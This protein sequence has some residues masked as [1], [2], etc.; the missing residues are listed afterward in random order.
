MGLG[1][2]LSIVSL[3][4]STLP[5]ARKFAHAS[6][7]SGDSDDSSSGSDDDDLDA[8]HFSS[9][10]YGMAAT[11]DLS[12]GK[13]RK[14]AEGYKVGPNKI[15]K[16]ERKYRQD[17]L[18]VRS[19]ATLLI[20]PLST[21]S[22]W[23]EQIRDHWKGK[24]HV[25]GGGSSSVKEGKKVDKNALPEKGDLKVY[26]YHGNSRKNDLEFLADFDVVITTFSVLQTEYSKQCK[27]AVGEQAYLAG[28]TAKGNPSKKAAAPAQVATPGASD[29]SMEDD[30]AMEVDGGK[31]KPEVRAERLAIQADGKKKHRGGDADTFGP[32][33]TKEVVSPLQAVEWFRV[34][35]DEAQ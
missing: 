13:K 33:T 4:A 20:C 8:D 21:V 6:V 7:K 5:S 30:D 22:N 2:T 25:V 16:L 14:R 15:A 18:Q 17:R 9:A 27:T 3:I 10:V 34:V 32:K 28:T 24:V 26:V 35:L 31:E 11:A 23:E 19:R 12:G 29:A 1:K